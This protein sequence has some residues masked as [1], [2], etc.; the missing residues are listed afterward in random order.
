MPYGTVTACRIG[1]RVIIEVELPDRGEPSR[2]EDE[3][4]TS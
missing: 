1:S 4:R 2:A 3:R